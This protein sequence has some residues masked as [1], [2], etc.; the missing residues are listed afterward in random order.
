MQ[1]PLFSLPQPWSL[2][3]DSRGDLPLRFYEPRYVELARRIEP[4][5]GNALFGYAERGDPPEPGDSGVLVNG[6]QFRWLGPT[7]RGPIGV[8]ANT[9]G[10]RFRV[11]SVRAEKAEGDQP[12]LYVGHVQLLEQQD[13]ARLPGRRAFPAA[14]PSSPLSES[15]VQLGVW[16]FGSYHL[17]PSSPGILGGD[18]AGSFISFESALCAALQKLDDGSPLPERK[19]FEDTRYDPKT[20]TFWATVRW[21]APSTCQGAER[22]EVQMVFD[23]AFGEIAA[24][25][26]RFFAPGDATAP[27][28]KVHRF[29]V[30]LRYKR[31]TP[32]MGDPIDAEKNALR[33][34]GLGGGPVRAGD[35]FVAKRE[36]IVFASVTSWDKLST[37]GQGQAV[38]ARGPPEECEGYIM[39]PI[40]PAGAVELRFLERKRQHIP[41]VAAPVPSSSPTGARRRFRG[42]QQTP[43]D[44]F[45]LA[46]REV[47]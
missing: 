36:L 32:A 47:K 21:P 31:W 33:G 12:P 43:G 14:A 8:T 46:D 35:R 15:F 28:M 26:I 20:R 23:E 16:G 22:W 9:D 3:A 1:I 25:E 18:G 24:G 7:S 10:R 29:G 13:V 6:R 27:P 41:D 5:A 4:P 38:I 19:M 44:P 40:Q 11:L 2:V 37:V 17:G 42:A 39:V 30:E 34:F 45:T